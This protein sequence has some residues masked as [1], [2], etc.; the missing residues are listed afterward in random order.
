MGNNEI[1]QIINKLRK[2][3]HNPNKYYPNEDIIKLIKGKKYYSLYDMYYI[4]RKCCVIE[5]KLEL[6][7]VFSKAT[8]NYAIK[9]IIAT[10]KLFVHYDMLK[11]EE[12]EQK[13]LSNITPNGKT[14]N[15]IEE[16]LNVIYEQHCNVEYVFNFIG[17]NIV[18]EMTIE[19]HEY[20]CKLHETIKRE[21]FYAI[22]Q[23][24]MNIINKNAL[25]EIMI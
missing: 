25:F 1:I 19:G 2:F 6:M 22:I 3:T 14:C 15:N 8:K 21:Y 24:P 10:I 5:P 20:W 23:K 9:R 12:I 4:C 16:L 17:R 7:E 18:W 11:F 13:I